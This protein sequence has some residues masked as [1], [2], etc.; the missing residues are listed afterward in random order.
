MTHSCKEGA[1]G[2]PY[3][4]ISVLREEIEGLKRDATMLREEVRLHINAYGECTHAALDN[5]LSKTPDSAAW[6]E[7]K[8][9]EVTGPLR[10][11]IRDLEDALKSEGGLTQKPKRPVDL[12]LGTDQCCCGKC[13][14]CEWTR[15]QAPSTEDSKEKKS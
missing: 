4:K 11:R 6:L 14:N 2:N 5:A 1:K 7:G 12:V 9:E 15:K 10:E 8:I 13:Q 3:C